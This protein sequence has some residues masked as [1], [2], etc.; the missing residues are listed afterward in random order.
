MPTLTATIDTLVFDAQAVVKAAVSERTPET[1]DALAVI[2]RDGLHV[3]T[4]PPPPPPPPPLGTGAGAGAG[5]GVLP[6]PDAQAVWAIAGMEPATT[7]AATAKNLFMSVP[8][9]VGLDARLNQRDD[10]HGTRDMAQK[11]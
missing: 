9:I 11:S 8:F 6:P 7:N 4:P 5:G 1:V 3:F 10:C 2:P